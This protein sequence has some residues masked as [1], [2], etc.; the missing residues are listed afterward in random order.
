MAEPVRLVE[1]VG[2]LALATDLGTGQ[3]LEHAIRAALL[4]VRIAELSGL[5]ED[6]TAEVVKEVV[7]ADAPPSLLNAVHARTAGNPFFVT[8]VARLYALRGGDP[9]DV[10]KGVQQVLTRRLAHLSQQG[11]EILALAA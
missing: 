2:A 11:A 10:P 9:I 8:E 7:G 4:S 3:P 6:A 1:L 5:D